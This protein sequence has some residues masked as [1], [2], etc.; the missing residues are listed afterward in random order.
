VIP[1]SPLQFNFIIISVLKQN[2]K[3][4]LAGFYF[5]PCTIKNFKK[6][7]IT[8]CFVSLSNAGGNS[9]PLPKMI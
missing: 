6:S 5:C 4:W 8:A 2:L 9:P 1:D 3:L 7:T